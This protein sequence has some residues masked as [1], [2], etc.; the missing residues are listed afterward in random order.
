MSPVAFQRLVQFLFQN[1]HCAER[2]FL[3]NIKLPGLRSACC[4][5]VR[6]NP[7]NLPMICVPDFTELLVFRHL[8]T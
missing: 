7:Q 3:R 5:W 4:N 6:K 8:A 1:S 2:I